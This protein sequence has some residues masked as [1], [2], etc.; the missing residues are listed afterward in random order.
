MP[1]RASGG[2]R[3]AGSATP[4]P[5]V[6]AAT[7]AGRGRGGRAARDVRQVLRVRWGS[8]LFILKKKKRKKT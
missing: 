8:G 7:T 5:G 3:A 1:A 4:P 2:E 6:S